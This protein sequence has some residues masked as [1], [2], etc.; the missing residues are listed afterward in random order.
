MGDVAAQF[1]QAV[2]S[3]VRLLLCVAIAVGVTLVVWRAVR[4]R[5]EEI[6]EVPEGATPS[7]DMMNVALG[8]IIAAFVFLS[9][10][11]VAQG[12]GNISAARTAVSDEQIAAT[13]LLAA[14]QRLGSDGAPIAQAVRDYG[15]SVITTEWDAL[16]SADTDAASA[17]HSA[18]SSGVARVIM[19]LEVGDVQQMALADISTRLITSGGDRISALPSSATPGLLLVLGVLGIVSL[20][21]GVILAPQNPK[22][23]VIILVA[24]A[25]SMAFLYFLT[26]ETTNAYS[27]GVIVSPPSLG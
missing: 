12:F 24:L 9:A 7:E 21:L 3:G 26:V 6:L 20:G 5:T 18:A 10:F 8:G 25:T 17:A 14:A 15:T 2:P 4:G 1:M 11:M 13:Q 16:R 19:G 22:A 27:T 23:S